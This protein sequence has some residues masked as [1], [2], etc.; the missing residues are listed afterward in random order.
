MGPGQ[1]TLG[2]EADPGPPEAPPTGE[3]PDI[4][5]VPSGDEGVVAEVPRTEVGPGSTIDLD[6]DVE[7]LVRRSVDARPGRSPLPSTCPFLR[8]GDGTTSVAP[9]PR[10]DPGHRCLALAEPMA[11]GALQQEVVCLVPA[12]VDCPRYARGLATARADLAIGGE[13]ARLP[14]A[15]RVAAALVAVVAALVLAAF[16]FSGGLKLPGTGATL[17]P[18]TA[19]PAPTAS[20]SPTATPTPTPSPTVSPT[21]SPSPTLSPSPSP[22]PSPSAT[23]TAAP[24][25][26]PRPSTTDPRYAGLQRCPAPQT[27]YIYIARSYST[28]SSIASYFR[29]TVAVIEQLNPQIDPVTHTIHTGEPIKIPPPR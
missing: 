3:A 23:P 24:T 5:S 28:V 16:L 12:H 17:P 9:G 1:G 26:T 4:G 7:T 15:V 22:S 19:T 11:P 29:T 27:C 18:P 6:T 10:P 25:A 13:G 20:P 2:L 8:A 14:P 21:P